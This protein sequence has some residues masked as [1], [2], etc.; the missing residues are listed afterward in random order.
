MTF[1]LSQK[2]RITLVS[3]VI[4]YLVS[5][6]CTYRFT[7][8]VIGGTAS[9]GANGLVCPTTWGLILHALV[10]GAIT[11]ALMFIPNFP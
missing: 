2:V 6:A 3:M 1:H 11:Y 7:N 5:M 10:F 4:F 8:A 9:M